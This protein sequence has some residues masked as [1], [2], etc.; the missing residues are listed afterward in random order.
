MR[1]TLNTRILLKHDTPEKWNETFNLTITDDSVS[2]IIE[3]Q[4]VQKYGSISF[5]L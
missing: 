1:N 5:S 3:I 2:V 4:E